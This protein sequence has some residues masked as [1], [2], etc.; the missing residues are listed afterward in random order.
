MCLASAGDSLA[1]CS[2]RLLAS[3]ETLIPSLICLCCR[4]ATRLHPTRMS[5]CNI[6]NLLH[7]GT[8]RL[9]PTHSVVFAA[10]QDILPTSCRLC[11]DRRGH[12]RPLDAC[13]VRQRF[14]IL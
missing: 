4:S 6:N 13:V 5:H 2:G 7:V 12:S 11:T 10:C 14:M 8:V 9:R 1:G 3:P